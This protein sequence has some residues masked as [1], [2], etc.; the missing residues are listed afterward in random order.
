MSDDNVFDFRPL[1]T[2]VDIHTTLDRRDLFVS[3]WLSQALSSPDPRTWVSE[4]IVAARRRILRLP[5]AE[6][7]EAAKLELDEL[8][9]W[10][11]CGIAQAKRPHP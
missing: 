1:E 3:R 2:S 6:M 4:R 11:L 5:D 10:L 8:E 7:A 9:Y